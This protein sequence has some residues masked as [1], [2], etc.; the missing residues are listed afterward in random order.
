MSFHISLK[1]DQ[2]MDYKIMDKKGFRVVGKSIKVTTRNGENFRRIPKFWDECIEDGSCEQ[3]YKLSSNGDVLG[4]CMEFCNEQDEFTYM[5]AAETS[6]AA[7][8][9]MVEKEIPTATWAVFQSIGPMPG[10]IQAVTQRIFSEWF[11]A[12]GYEHA[13]APELEVYPPG[14]GSDPNYRCEVWIPIVRKSNL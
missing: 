6:E 10:A 11:P 14:N 4:I 1:G 13:D 7:P 8:A 3:I 12:T 5:I 9:G 2:D